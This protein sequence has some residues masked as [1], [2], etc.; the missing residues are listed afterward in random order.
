M[1][2]TYQNAVKIR[3]VVRFIVIFKSYAPS[4]IERQFIKAKKFACTEL[5]FS[6]SNLANLLLKV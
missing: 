1:K 4:N 5:I 2:K 3:A 6:L